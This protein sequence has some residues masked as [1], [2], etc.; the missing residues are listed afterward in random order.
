MLEHCCP[1]VTCRLTD[2]YGNPINPYEPDSV[3]YTVLV[4]PRHRDKCECCPEPNNRQVA[5]EGYVAVYS[6]EKR[7]SPPIPFCIIESLCLSTLKGNILT[8]QVKVF[9]CWV[10]PVWCEVS[11]EM[12]E[13]KLLI[14][15]ETVASSKEAASL[16]VPQVDSCLHV[17]DR[18]CIMANRICDSVQF[19]SKCCICYRNIALKANISQYNTISDGIKR[20]YL[21]SDELKEYGDQG[22]LSP[23][24]VSYYNVFVNAVLQPKAN[25]V[26]KEGE[27]TFTT[28]NVPSK[29]Q[30]VMILFNT[31]K[32]SQC[33]TMPVDDWQ[34]NAVSDGEKKIYTNEDELK[35]YGNHGIPSPSEVSY[36]NLYINGVLQPTVN[37]KVIK[38]VL[39]LTTADAP[40]KGALVILE[41][42]IIWDTA[43][44][45]IH[46]ETY[47]Y[48]TRSNGGKIYT[49]QDEIR[50]YG[51]QGISIPDENFYQ[52]LFV[53]GVLQPNV[54]Y[55]VQK[56]YLILNTE[57]SPT[58]G[59]PISLQFVS[60]SSAPFCCKARMSD[61]AL[62]QWE[63]RYTQ[64]KEPCLPA[65]PIKEPQKAGK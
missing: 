50:M 38:G 59:A 24:E 22:I 45:L 42:I 54:N 23:Q 33:Q 64:I 9:H 62:A 3:V 63:K 47:A 1:L 12:E 55:M 6:E 21:N 16:L 36:F 19:N 60:N 65:H 52:S 43:G 51:N 32:D 49:S 4:L 28:Q 31:L 29:G 7:T 11:S 46:M 27:L 10:V 20:T 15:V 25:Y 2:R 8:F 56:G 40:V 34:Y 14:N 5:I 44:Q 13:I 61:A 57:D 37:Y 17:I 35:K 41:S 48:N 26:L 58:V 30:A 53:N 39:E 18:V